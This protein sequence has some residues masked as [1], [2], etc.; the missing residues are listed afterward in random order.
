[1]SAADRDL[2]ALGAALAQHRP[3]RLMAFVGPRAAR[4][5]VAVIARARPG[6]ERGATELL[7]IERGR[8]DGDPWSGNM[9]FPGGRADPG[10]ADAVATAAREAA[11][12]VGVALDRGA[13]LGRLSPI[14]AMTHDKRRPMVVEPV[15]FALAA[16]DAPLA[17]APGEVAAAVWIPL[18]A[19]RGRAHRARH[20]HRVLG[21]PWPFPAWRVDGR[22]IWGLTHRMVTELLRATR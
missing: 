18:G 5:A 3:A 20:R 8:R 6:E 17:L 4:A 15:V 7:F 13:V 14:V 2:G 16:G 11:E 1:M 21:V 22:T 9:A 12:E 10:D 19:L